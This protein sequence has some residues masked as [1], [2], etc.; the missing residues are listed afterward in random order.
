ME[1]IPLRFRTGAASFFLPA[2]TYSPLSVCEPLDHSGLRNV[3][4]VFWMTAMFVY[5][6]QQSDMICKS[7]KVCCT[8]KY[9]S[10]LAV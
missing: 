8:I 5:D 3:D 2:C 9:S 10:V 6:V 7:A 4:R 1:T